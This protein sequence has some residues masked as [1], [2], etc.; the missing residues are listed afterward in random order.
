MENLISI[1]RNIEE[2]AGLAL[3]ML[4]TMYDGFMK[5]DLD[6]LLGVLN[7]EARL[8]DMEKAITLALIDL[9]KGKIS[10]SDKKNI[11]LL[12]NIVADLEEIGDYVKDMIERIEIKIQENLLFSDEALSEYKHLYS[13]VEAG[14][15]DVVNSLKMNDK[16]FAKRALGDEGH[17]DD[18]VQKYRQTHTQR[19][20]SGICLPFACNMFL[21]LLD[22]SAQ[23]YHHTKIIAQNILELK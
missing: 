14:L 6:I 3:S 22:F 20:I 23:I 10:D 19:L 15:S 1:R 12:T 16:N 13:V 7:D 21:N 9:S 5:H 8:N 17:V 4:K 18:L 2:M 11:M